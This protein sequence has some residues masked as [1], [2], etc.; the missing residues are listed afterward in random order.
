MKTTLRLTATALILSTG[1]FLGCRKSEVDKDTQSSVDFSVAEAGFSGVLPVMNQIGIDEDGLNKGASCA[2]ITWMNSQD[3]IG[4]N[5]WP[6]IILVDYGTVGCADYDG[7]FKQGSFTAVFHNRFGDEGAMIDITL[8]DYK[9]NTV[10][11]RGTITLKNNGGRSYSSTVAN[12]EV[13]LSDGSTILYD[14][15]STLTWLSGHTTPSDASDDSF[16]FT[17]DSECT[18][19]E[20]RHFV[21]TT[22][23]P[24]LK[25]SDC[26]YITS[27]VLDLTPDELATRSVN[28]GDGSCDD[29]ASVTVNGNT[30]V[31]KLN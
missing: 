12:G 16:E 20:D 29:E 17:N 4:I 15:T 23:T 3:T 8:N 11:Y 26:E 31:F 21:V 30:F 28:Y 7:K 6:V 10:E 18:N 9:V 25:S 27:G 19:R 13:V 22:T 2:T 1:L 14:G 5:N 24:L